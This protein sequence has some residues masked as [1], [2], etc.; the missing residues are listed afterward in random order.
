LQ[1]K[2]PTPPDSNADNQEEHTGSPVAPLNVK[3][4]CAT[5]KV[6]TRDFVGCCIKSLDIA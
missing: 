5:V 2:L 3:A 4:D 1:A 6:V